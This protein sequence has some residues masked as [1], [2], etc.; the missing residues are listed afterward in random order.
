MSQ[1][2]FLA[3]LIAARDDQSLLARYDRR[4]LAQLV[5]HAQND[6]FDFTPQDVALVVGALEANVILNKDKSLYDGTAP[7][8]RNMWGYR[9]LDYVVN[10]V[11]RKHS[12][13]ELRAI[14]KDERMGLL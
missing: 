13:E 1:E 2:S 9:H 3:F 7:L 12:T 6:G 5:F 14:V 4:N 11:V 8:W 10:Q